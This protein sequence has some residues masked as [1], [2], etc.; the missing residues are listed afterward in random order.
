MK[1]LQRLSFLHL[2]PFEV[3]MS[4]IESGIG[5]KQN[6]GVE[7]TDLVKEWVYVSNKQI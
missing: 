3:I 7:E 2:A 1:Q 6:W 5:L 4:G